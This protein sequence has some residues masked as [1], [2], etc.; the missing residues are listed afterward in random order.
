MK[1]N[2][3][4]IST[5]LSFEKKLHDP[6]HRGEAMYYNDELN[7]RLRKVYDSILRQAHTEGN[8]P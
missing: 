2:R 5:I 6:K 4:L 3:R 8:K 7:P 1:V